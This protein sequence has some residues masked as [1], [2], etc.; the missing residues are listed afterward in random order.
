MSRPSIS[1]NRSESIKDIKLHRPDVVDSHTISR[2]NNETQFAKQK[3][4]DLL[5][6]AP[7]QSVVENILDRDRM[8]SIALPP[9]LSEPKLPTSA[10]RQSTPRLS[11]IIALTPSNDTTGAK[12]K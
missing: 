12:S 10:P 4:E 1:N 5:F 11:T 7:R 2:K 9:T 6:L 8:Y 3:N